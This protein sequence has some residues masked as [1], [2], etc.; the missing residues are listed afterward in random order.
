MNT[1]PV[2][3]AQMAQYYQQSKQSPPAFAKPKGWPMRS[4]AIALDKIQLFIIQV[5]I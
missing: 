1:N 4:S 5:A 3:Y 2:L